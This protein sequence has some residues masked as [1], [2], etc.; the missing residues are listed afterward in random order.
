[1]KQRKKDWFLATIDLLRNRFYTTR[2]FTTLGRAWFSD[3]FTTDPNAR[4]KHLNAHPELKDLLPEIGQS[5]EA[6]PAFDKSGIEAYLKATL[7]R[8]GIKPGILVNGIRVAL[9]GQAKGPEFMS[10]LMAL[11]QDRVSCRLKAAAQWGQP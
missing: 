3:D 10:S 11:G 7:D 5:L 9:T 6:L 8:T 4:D 1:M 2:D